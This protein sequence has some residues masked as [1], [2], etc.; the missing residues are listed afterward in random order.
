MTPIEEIIEILDCWEVMH[1]YK[2]LPDQPLY[3]PMWALR[4]NS[5]ALY[6]YWMVA[7]MMESVDEDLPHDSRE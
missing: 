1:A 6:T 4:W 7:N 2:K 3:S 5:S